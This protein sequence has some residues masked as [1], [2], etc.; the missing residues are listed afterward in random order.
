M[1]FKVIN[2]TYLESVSGG[3]I[4]ILREVANIFKTQVPEFISEMKSL[5]S[6]KDYNK[7]GLLAHKAKSSIAIMGMEDLVLMLKEFEINARGNID[8]EKYDSYISR[9]EKETAAA[10]IEL[11]RYLDSH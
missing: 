10:I 7:L 1:E 8:S 6:I 4:E 3:D 11:D 5:L 9:F 2:F